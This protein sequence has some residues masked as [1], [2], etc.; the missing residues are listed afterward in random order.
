MRASA[1]RFWL[2]GVLSLCAC[3]NPSTPEELPPLSFQRFAMDAENGKN[4]N[5]K[6][7]N[8]TDLSSGDMTNFLVSVNYNPARWTPYGGEMENVWLQGTS[9]FGQKDGHIYRDE[10]FIGMEFQGNLGGGGTVRVRIRGMSPAPAPNDDLH[11]YNVDYFDTSTNAWRS[12]CQ[13]D[14][15]QPLQAMPVQGVWNYQQGVTG[16]G[17]KV[18][19]PD[20]FTFACMGGAIAKCALWG[21]R[22]WG[23]YNGVALEQYHQACTRLVRAD[24]CGDGVSYTKTGNRIDLYDDLGLQQDTEAWVFEAE[25]DTQGARCFYALNRSHSQL[26]C[27]NQRMDFL[28]GQ[29]LGGTGTSALLFNETPGTLGIDPGL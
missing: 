26:P 8:G 12:A 18:G 1:F 4:L 16:G 11:L 24:Y 20:R 10:D 3:A 5:G 21:Y 6:N 27:F 23:S 13:D 19:T 7:L 22:P 15:G 29:N 25:W 28:C 14:T 2:A 17:S 9:F